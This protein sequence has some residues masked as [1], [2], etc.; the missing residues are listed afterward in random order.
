MQC[1]GAGNL[2][3]WP[4]WSSALQHSLCTARFWSWISYLQSLSHSQ[5]GWW[6]ACAC[7][8]APLRC[9]GYC[10]PESAITTTAWVGPTLQSGHATLSSHSNSPPWCF[11]GSRSFLQFHTILQANFT[12]QRV[13]LLKMGMSQ[14]YY[15][16]GIRGAAEADFSSYWGESSSFSCCS[17]LAS[18]L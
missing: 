16:V 14:E 4:L 6:D 2:H 18:A 5:T 7:E 1:V 3:P 8:H 10:R 13:T 9:Q 17:S 15:T 12:S 11:T